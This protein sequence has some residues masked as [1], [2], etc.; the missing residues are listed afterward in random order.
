M[1]RWRCRR[2]RAALVDHAA[3]TLDAQTGSALQRHLA[4]CELCRGE[5]AALS[6]VPAMLRAL[7]S[8]LPAEEIWARQRQTIG[9]LVRR[10][11]DPQLRA[12]RLWDRLPAMQSPAWRLPVAAFASLLLTLSV[13]RFVVAPNRALRL[14]AV[15]P[16]AALDDESLVE[17][18]DVVGLVAP[19]DEP[20]AS[21]LHDDDMLASLPLVDLIGSNP[22]TVAIFAADEDGAVDANDE[23]AEDM[24]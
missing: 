14:A 7:P 3:G 8:E 22:G 2:Y 23:A 20:L 4:V 13:Y 16:V 18:H 1:I 17:L 10:A 9:R 6:E 19:R 12:G 21:S 11:P 5:A 24:G 15:L